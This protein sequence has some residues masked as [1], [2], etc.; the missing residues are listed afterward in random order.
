MSDLEKLR[1]ELQKELEG[2]K[3]DAALKSFGD[4]RILRKESPCAY[5]RVLM[6]LRLG[7]IMTERHRP[8]VIPP[9]HAAGL[10]LLRSDRE[11]ERA[12]EAAEGCGKCRT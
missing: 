6:D 9:E 2:M 7:F 12:F 4:L 10:A 3:A 8:L 1:G 5:L 11:L